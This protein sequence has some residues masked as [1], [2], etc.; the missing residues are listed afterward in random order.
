MRLS[1]KA[2]L[3]AE[4]ATWTWL[5]ADCHVTS[6]ITSMVCKGWSSLL[7]ATA[8]SPSACCHITGN[9]GPH[10][11]A[12]QTSCRAG[13]SSAPPRQ[14]GASYVPDSCAPASPLSSPRELAAPCT[15]RTCVR[16]QRP[17]AHTV[18]I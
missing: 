14:P 17:H 3:G 11:S 9:L 7:Q 1:I 6:I 16:A 8:Q 12:K 10:D 4:A 13:T 5:W 15:R 18:R 2:T